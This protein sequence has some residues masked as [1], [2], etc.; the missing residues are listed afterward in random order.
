[1]SVM[2]LLNNGDVAA[3]Q[4]PPFPGEGLIVYFIEDGSLTIIARLAFGAQLATIWSWR[5]GDKE[6]VRNYVC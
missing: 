6:W 1:M 2:S 3:P 4:A 5:V